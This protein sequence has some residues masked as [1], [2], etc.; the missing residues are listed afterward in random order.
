MS[1]K[2]T[3]CGLLNAVFGRRGF[4]PRRSASTTSL[5]S[6]NTN[7]NEFV[8]TANTP[9]SKR[10][11]GSSDEAS[12]IHVPAE[13]SKPA[14][15]VGSN[16]QSQQRAVY[17]NQQRGVPMTNQNEGF[18]VAAP[19]SRVAEAAAAGNGYVDRGRKVPKEAV[20]ISGELELMIADHQKSKGTNGSLVR[21][22]SS[23]VML[24]G[25]LGNIIN[26]FF[27]FNYLDFN[28]FRIPIV[29]KVSIRF[30]MSLL[31]LAVSDF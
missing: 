23:N 18:K 31:L 1:E 19:P 6:M 28:G 24:F 7:N 8:K 12:F 16:Q 15:K 22:S 5:A 10:R 3:S 11:R 17:S 14:N 2:K 29:L 26:M 27:R 25:N 20:G 9:N 4:W 13:E 21:A 30:V